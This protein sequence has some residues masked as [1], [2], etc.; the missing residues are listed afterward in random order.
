MLSWKLLF[1]VK[2]KNFSNSIGFSPHYM[3]YLTVSV[4]IGWPKWTGFYLLILSGYPQ[5]AGS[6]NKVEFSKDFHIN[7]LKLVNA[8]MKS[9]VQP[10]IFFMG[11]NWPVFLKLCLLHCHLLM[12]PC[13]LHLAHTFS[14]DLIY[15]WT[16]LT[17][18]LKL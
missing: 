7:L 4:W 15:V 13:S 18:S 3:L 14:C 9:I 1:N 2:T 6:K 17:Y 11:Q 10:N 16:F 8:V 5:E 12:K